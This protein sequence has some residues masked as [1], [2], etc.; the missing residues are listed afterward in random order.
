MYNYVSYRVNVFLLCK[1]K[2]K[3]LRKTK[4]ENM[5]KMFSEANLRKHFNICVIIVP[6]TGNGLYGNLLISSQGEGSISN[7]LAGRRKKMS[8]TN[9]SCRRYS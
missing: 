9:S 6:V 8:Q 2:S 7:N 3:I 5:A 1:R 4:L